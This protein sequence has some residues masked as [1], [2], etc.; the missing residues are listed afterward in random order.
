MMEWFEKYEIAKT[1]PHRFLTGSEIRVREPL[2][3][4]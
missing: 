1:V 2:E 4:V 3:N